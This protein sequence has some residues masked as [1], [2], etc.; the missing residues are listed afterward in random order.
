M[1]PL[2]KVLGGAVLIAALA[3]AGLVVFLKILYPPERIKSLAVEALSK[4]LG[5]EIR[6]KN[7]SIGLWRGISLEGLAVSEQPDFK[8]GTFLTADRISARP[9]LEPLLH[10]RLVLQRLT[11]EAPSVR[12]I[13]H[14]GGKFN[15]SDL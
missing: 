3:L 12:I 5:R 15:F 9:S 8:A 1:K 7:A 6:L 11:L 14:A 13:R 10:R 2:L 4:R